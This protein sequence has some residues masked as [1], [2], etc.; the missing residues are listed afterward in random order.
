[1]LN[2]ERHALFVA[3]HYPPESSSS[4]VLRTLK[5]TRYLG[6]FG[7]R[8]TVLTLDRRAYDTVDPLL[9]AQVP[10]DV[11]VVRTPF[12]EVKRHL[13]VRGWYPS[14]L[15]IPDRSIGWLPWAVAAGRRIVRSDL[16]D[17]IYSTSPHA[18]A[19]LIAL[20]I[21]RR[22]RVP[23]VVDFRDPWYE[24]PP[25]PGTTRIRQ[26]AARR[27]ERRVVARAD[28]IVASTARLRNML[29][30]RYP[31]KPQEAFLAIPNGYDEGDFAHIAASANPPGNEM[32]IV[33]AGSI[34][35]NF[36]DPRPVFEAVQRAVAE[37]EIERSRIRLRF[38][39]AGPF[40]DSVAMREAVRQA[41]LTSNVEFRP[42]LSYQDSLLEQSRA[43]VLL[44]LQA[45]PDTIDL[46]PAKLFEYLRTRRPV[47]ALVPEGATSE[48]LRETGGGWVVEPG[49]SHVLS[50]ILVTAYRAWT[51][52]RLGS[53]AA[54]PQRLETFSRE[55]LAAAL[56]SQFDALVGDVSPE[57]NDSPK[58]E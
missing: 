47:L 7:W 55:R 29:A 28:R 48:V 10:A 3:Y 8:V 51:S 24:D 36:R 46:V 13:A 43:S 34:N 38:L 22:A 40:G 9:E 11:R 53:L 20:S 35:E 33:H 6:R 26:F 50:A 14:I 52:G 16:V 54:D 49:D 57:N 2:G 56:A 27:L 41:G 32:L 23:W 17:V 37:G 45:S 25:E 30:A 58:L 18:T 5:H 42:R 39:G 15:A 31:W 1:L 44:L 12:I 21:V 4:G 19:H